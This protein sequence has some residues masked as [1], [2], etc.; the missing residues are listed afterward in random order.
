[1]NCSDYSGGYNYGFTK[2]KKKKK[3]R[4]KK[5]KLKIGYICTLPGMRQV[6]KLVLWVPFPLTFNKRV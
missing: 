6:T 5:R 2:K 3:E 1:M 4:K